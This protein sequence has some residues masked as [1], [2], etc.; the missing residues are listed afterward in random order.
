MAKLRNI[1]LNPETYTQLP[2]LLDNKEIL[3]HCVS[4]RAQGES[5]C[6]AP[7]QNN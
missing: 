3:S 7:V 1:T 5:H 4:H 2:N 6:D